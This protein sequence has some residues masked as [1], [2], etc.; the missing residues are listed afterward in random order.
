MWQRSFESEPQLWQSVV[1]GDGCGALDG[2]DFAQSPQHP[3]L[4][5]VPFFSPDN[6]A[7]TYDYPLICYLHDDNRSEQDL[8]KW[9]PAISDQNYLAVGAR[10][11]FPSQT[12]M[13]GQ[14]RWRGQRPGATAA[15]I[16]ESI[17]LVLRGWNV[18]PDRIYLFGEG[19]G[20]VA[21]LQQFMLAQLHR[22][23]EEEI[24]FAGVI[25]R[26]LPA[27]WARA[28]PPIA[29]F[30]SGRI[31][32]MDPM[33]DDEDGEAPAAID[34]L[35]ESGIAVTLLSD[36]GMAPA[37]AINHWIMGGISTAVH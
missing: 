6:W 1:N 31:L 27:W 11:P 32:L 15:V 28:L 8:W 24:R 17:E 12:A 37:N 36:S 4:A 21:A 14:F 19:N 5:G 29:D 16:Q 26:D 25:C 30:A 3:W 10:A 2:H 9:F 22:E 20:A 7:A 13:P 18:H 34:G 33:L 35:S 23:T